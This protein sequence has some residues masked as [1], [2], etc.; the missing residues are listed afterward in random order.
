MAEK[1]RGHTYKDIPY[2]NTGFCGEDIGVAKLSSGGFGTLKI[3]GL[4]PSAPGG[5]ARSMET[6]RFVLISIVSTKRLAD[7]PYFPK[8]DL[9]RDNRDICISAADHPGELFYSGGITNTVR[10][11]RSLI[12]EAFARGPEPAPPIVPLGE[13]WPRRK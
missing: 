9:R 10:V 8:Y 6:T 4:L 11:P 12:D 5:H 3:S 1:G 13:V 7:N 2:V